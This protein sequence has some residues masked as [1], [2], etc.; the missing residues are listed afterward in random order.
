MSVI[1]SIACDTLKKSNTLKYG[2][3]LKSSVLIQITIPRGS[4]PFP[5]SINLL[6]SLHKYPLK[7]PK[8]SLS[9]QQKNPSTFMDL[10]FK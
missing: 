2:S 4:F 5:K 10:S 7:N 3:L 8:N 9:R 6:E 1:I